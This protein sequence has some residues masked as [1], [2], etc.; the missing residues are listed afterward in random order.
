LREIERR[1]EFADGALATGEEGQDGTAT[2]FG[3][4]SECGFH[5][6]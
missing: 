1:L 2:W 3:K 6:I 5:G 4:D